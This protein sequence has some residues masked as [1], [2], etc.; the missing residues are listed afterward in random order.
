MW[1]KPPTPLVSLLSLLLLFQ[2]VVSIAAAAAGLDP[3]KVPARRPK[4]PPC[5][6]KGDEKDINQLF[7]EGASMKCLALSMSRSGVI[8]SMK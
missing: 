1:L 5:L 7:S 8:L 6:A 4:E 2:H 3:A